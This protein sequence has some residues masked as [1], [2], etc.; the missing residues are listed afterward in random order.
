[1]TKRR[2]FARPLPHLSYRIK[3]KDRPGKYPPN[4]HIKAEK[5]M[6]QDSASDEKGKSA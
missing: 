1:M 6:P 2:T 5:K 3:K 4:A